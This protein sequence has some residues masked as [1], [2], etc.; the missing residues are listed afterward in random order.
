M[1]PKDKG[2]VEFDGDVYTLEKYNGFTPCNKKIYDSEAL[3]KAAA[4]SFKTKTNTYYC[5]NCYGYHLTG[6]TK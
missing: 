5:R 4:L 3:A 1:K 2:A 6:K